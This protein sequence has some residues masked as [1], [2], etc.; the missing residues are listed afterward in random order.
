MSWATTFSGA[1]G[2]QYQRPDFNIPG[3]APLPVECPL[4]DT[5][6]A[7]K[8]LEEIV[9]EQ[10]AALHK[11]LQSWTVPPK[12]VKSILNDPYCVF[13]IE[14]DLGLDSSK[15]RIHWKEQVETLKKLLPT[16]NGYPFDLSSLQINALLALY[17]AETTKT[18]TVRAEIWKR[19]GQ[20]PYSDPTCKTKYHHYLLNEGNYELFFQTSD[21]KNLSPEEK[22]KVL[23][24]CKLA[25]LVDPGFKRFLD[26]L[27]GSDVTSYLCKSLETLL[28]S[29]EGR[30]V[31]FEDTPR[32][33]ACLAAFVSGTPDLAAKASKAMKEKG[34]V[35]VY[36][37]Q[38]LKIYSVGLEL[39]THV[40]KKSSEQDVK[41]LKDLCYHLKEYPHS[42]YYTGNCAPFAAHFLGAE[43]LN[44]LADILKE[45]G[46]RLVHG[47]H[48]VGLVKMWRQIQSPDVLK[49]ILAQLDVGRRG[50]P[51]DQLGNSSLTLTDY[52]TL[53]KILPQEHADRWRVDANIKRCQREQERQRY[54]RT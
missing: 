9:L 36:F 7:V 34:W 1:P 48:W 44:C 30:G 15:V 20:D 52:E 11:L 35:T 12:H 29:N 40:R 10:Q 47:I 42:A 32:G 2:P 25:L 43:A 31:W 33:I 17:A 45:T 4:V 23:N 8:T 16:F 49:E 13:Y 19:M 50:Y 54:L 37:E 38:R 24:L 22:Q 21:F 6:T 27:E 26:S 51:Y 53:D 3:V 41:G 46:S 28:T 18:E 5:P 14:A 39:A